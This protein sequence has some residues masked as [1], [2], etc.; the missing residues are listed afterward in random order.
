M[1]L[2]YDYC[3]VSACRNRSETVHPW[4]ER[5]YHGNLPRSGIQRRVTGL[6]RQRTELSRFRFAQS[7][8]TGPGLCNDKASLRFAWLRRRSSS[9]EPAALELLSHRSNASLCPY[10]IALRRLHLEI[11]PF[12]GTPYGWWRDAAAAG[13][14]A[15][16]SRPYVDDKSHRCGPIQRTL[17]NQHVAKSDPANSLIA[18]LSA[19]L[20]HGASLTSALYRGLPVEHKVLCSYQLSHCGLLL[21]MV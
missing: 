16:H 13:P 20:A 11:T 17:S 5:C 3:S 9:V 2:G 6:R 12:G 15:R 10:S 14:S 19:L 21:G 18:A 8:A 7:S 4:D 1:Y